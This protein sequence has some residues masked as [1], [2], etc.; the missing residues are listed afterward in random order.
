[1]ASAVQS[2]QVQGF[3]Q[4]GVVERKMWNTS[5]DG[6]VRDAHTI[7]GQTV[8]L[9]ESF[10]LNSGAQARAPAD[11]ALSAADRINCRCF[12]NPVFLDEDAVA[13]VSE[14]ATIQAGQTEGL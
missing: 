3:A 1:V 2:A 4:T 14:S 13:L 12:V 7:D 8:A 6:D 5:L 9:D 10:T 11:A